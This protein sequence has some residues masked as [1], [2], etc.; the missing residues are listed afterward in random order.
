[1]EERGKGYWRMEKGG[2]EKGRKGNGSHGKVR[3]EQG[4]RKQVIRQT[5]LLNAPPPQI[6][7]GETTI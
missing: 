4:S 2:K 1:M 5:I 6:C 7:I 3:Q